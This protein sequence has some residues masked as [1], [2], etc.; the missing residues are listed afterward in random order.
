MAKRKGRLGGTGPTFVRPLPQPKKGAKNQPLFFS[1]WQ[2]QETCLE[3]T[4]L[5][6][7]AIHTHV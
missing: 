3:N 2:N 5:D 1:E 4:C 7:N 6:I